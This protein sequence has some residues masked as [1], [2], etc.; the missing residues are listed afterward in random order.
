MRGT[1]IRYGDV[2]LK[3]VLIRSWQQEPVYDDSDTDL[4]CMK[5]VISVSAH[6]VSTENYSDAAARPQPTNR[7]GVWVDTDNDASPDDEQKAVVHFNNVKGLLLKPRQYFRL[8]MGVPLTGAADGTTMLEVQPME[9]RGGYWTG[10]DLKNGPKPRSCNVVKVISDTV[11]AVDWTIEVNVLIC[12]KEGRGPD[13]RTSSVLTNRWSVEDDIDSN[14][15]TTRT[16]SG[17]MTISNGNLTPHTFRGIVVPRLQPGFRRESMRFVSSKDGL[18]LDYTIRDREIG[19]SAPKPATS[20]SMRHTESAGD[21]M[22][23]RA[24]CQVSL[25][26]HRDVAHTD[27]ILVAMRCIHVKCFGDLNDNQL[28]VEDLQVTDYYGD[29]GHGVE[30]S[31]RVSRAPGG[32]KLKDGQLKAVRIITAELGKPVTAQDL[33]PDDYDRNRSYGGYDTDDIHVEGRLTFQAAFATYLQAPCD[34][35]HA[36]GTA[37]EKAVDDER[38][39]RGVVQITS[40][41]VDGDLPTEPETQLHAS[42][43]EYPYASYRVESKYLTDDHTV[44]LPIAAQLPAS[45]SSSAG[46]SGMGS[47]KTQAFVMLAPPTSRRIMRIEAQRVGRQPSLPDMPREYDYQV[48]GVPAK[49][50]RLSFVVSPQSP[51]RSSNGGM[52]YTTL[53]EVQYGMEIVADVLNQDLPVGPLPWLDDSINNMVLS[54]DVVDPRATVDS[55][56]GINGQSDLP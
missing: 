25:R 5:H 8:D 16:I 1:W 24:S 11:L 54:K 36:I 7:I 30:A 19:Y 3:N 21:G 2:T 40:A 35:N 53:A 22:M 37:E 55:T 47:Q 39:D 4:R 23:A 20:W 9:P 50:H 45:S 14:F 17:R 15:A 33:Q 48:G 18:E 12:D 10:Y 43:L 51:E 28:I 41:S 38:Y 31:A 46:G 52:V 56:L 32:K 13:D 6:V 49:A 26:S 34:D 42:H 44:G 27:L 29:D